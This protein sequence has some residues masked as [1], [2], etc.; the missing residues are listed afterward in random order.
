MST[1][2]KTMQ[3]VVCHGPQDY[4]LE[5]VETPQAGPGE[6]VIKVNAA[7][8]CASDLKCYMGAAIFWGDATRKGYAIPPVI[9]G[10]EF[11]GEVVELGEGAAEKHR[12]KLGDLAVAEQIIHA[13]NVG[14]AAPAGTGCAR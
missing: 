10:H 1:I 13:G 8:V 14:I 4:R 3:A 12:L 5:E 2:P 11:V 7:G 6:V 9:P